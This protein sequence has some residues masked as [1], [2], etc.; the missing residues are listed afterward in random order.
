MSP[1]PPQQ[2]PAV[3]TAEVEAQTLSWVERVVVGLELCPFA[4]STLS[5][6]QLRIAVCTTAEEPQLALAVL[7]ELERLQS[8]PETELA[9]TLLVM[10]AA[11]ADFEH[12]LDFL[13]L[14]EELLEECGLDGVVQI[15]SFH[16]QYR[17]AEVP[18]AD[19]ANYSNRSPYPM[20]HFL[21]EAQ[22][23]RALESYPDPERIPE[24]NI[25]RLRALGSPALLALLAEIC[26]GR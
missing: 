8:L 10:P 13:A 2:L 5:G 6:G 22:L 1:T 7:D 9:T 17:F 24:R 23:T 14:A 21:R 3:H 19:P 11:L 15:A 12:Y 4:A 18:A 26:A 20:L 25:Q 16:P